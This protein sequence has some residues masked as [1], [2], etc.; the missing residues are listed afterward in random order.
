MTPCIMINYNKLEVH[1]DTYDYL[2]QVQIENNSFIKEHIVG[3][4]KKLF[5]KNLLIATSSITSDLD[6][7]DLTKNQFNSFLGAFSKNLY[8]QFRNNEE[9]YYQKINFKGVAR[10]KNINNWDSVP[11]GTYFYNIDISSAYWQIAYKLGYINEKMFLNFLEVDSYKQAKRYCISFLART[12]RMLYT[13]NSKTFT[14]NCDTGV[15]RSVY[16]NIRNHLYEIIQTSVDLTDLWLEFNIDGVSVL[17]NDL[18]IVRDYFNHNN[19]KFKIV[20][21]KKLNEYE[22]LYK[23]DKRNFK[24]KTL[25]LC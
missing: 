15:F 19:L 5:N 23:G 12:N 17:N 24:R 20:E 18:N 4:R 6:L 16:E 9:L 22:Y 3:S 7:G 2:K 25:N 8:S 13:S 10:S 14:I 11:N 21:C 1:E